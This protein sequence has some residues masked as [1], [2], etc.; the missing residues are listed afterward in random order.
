MIGWIVFGCIAAAIFLWI[1]FANLAEKTK[2][3]KRDK[4]HKS[5]LASSVDK[6]YL[7]FIDEINP[8]DF[9]NGY[10]K[11]QYLENLL[12]AKMG[13]G[14]TFKRLSDMGLL[15][16]P[17]GNRS[18]SYSYSSSNTTFSLDK[19][20]PS[21][22]HGLSYRY[23]GENDVL[24]CRLL[25]LSLI[26]ISQYYAKEAHPEFEKIEKS[27]FDLNTYLAAVGIGE[28]DSSDPSFLQEARSIIG[29]EREYRSDYE[30]KAYQQMLDEARREAAK[31]ITAA[32]SREHR[33]Q[34]KQSEL[35]QQYRVALS[36]LNEEKKR[37]QQQA[38]SLEEQKRHFRDVELTGKQK[39]DCYQNEIKN[40]LKKIE[41]GD[42]R[43]IYPYLAGVIADIDTI[44]IKKAADA[45]DWGSDETRLKKVRSLN[46][47]R[48]EVKDQLTDARV[49]YYQLR[50]LLELFPSLQDI[51][52][53]EYDEIKFDLGNYDY[54]DQ[55]PARFFLTKDEWDNLTT[56]E[57]N[58]L[59]LDRYVAS[60][61]K[62]NWQIGR[63]YELYIG[64]LYLAKGYD[65]DFTGSYMGL[66]DMGRDLICKKNGKTV[67]IQ[68]KY[69]GKDKR[70]HENHINQLYGTMI[71]YCIE[72]NELQS[73]V[74]GRFV[75]NIELSDTAR[76]F[77]RMLGI[78][79]DE[80]VP[81]ESFPRIKCNIGVDEHGS[82]TKIY[83]LPMDLSYD[84]TKIDKKGEF[85]ARTVE[86]AENKGFRRS[87]KWKGLN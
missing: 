87:Y 15:T 29:L 86:E 7:R 57:R 60:H 22:L 23:I 36:E 10:T 76:K 11:E 28:D 3:N 38:S 42:H 78:K 26:L 43:V 21:F 72:N 84:V 1:V 79:F 19:S 68:C 58:Q 65:V 81:M 27:I 46:D 61:S 44:S 69:W 51:L 8:R 41:G 48:A 12:K 37:L 33:F 18:S 66:E 13:L 16:I 54:K 9:S 63:D 32:D 83:H 55:D 74:E 24:N 52:D 6:D 30:K 4:Q 39:V 56:T 45:L 73:N 20:V 49:A 17:K 67:I 31:A 25:R 71:S 34:E 14:D 35:N 47:L 62:N 75:T 53:S 77:A 70:I 2:Q 59:A 82:K 80:N 5:T 40:I 64:Q 85:F 50:Y